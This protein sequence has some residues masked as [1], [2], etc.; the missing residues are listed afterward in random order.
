[1]QAVIK[2][3][4]QIYYFPCEFKVTIT[5]TDVTDIKN[6][7]IHASVQ[8]P[9]DTPGNAELDCLITDKAMCRRVASD[10]FKL[11]C[12]NLGLDAHKH[13]DYQEEQYFLVGNPGSQSI[14]SI[15]S[16]HGSNDCWFAVKSENRGIRVT[17][18]LGSFH[19]NIALSNTRQVRKLLIDTYITN[20][21]NITNTTK[22]GV[23]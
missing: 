16:I 15:Q 11:H 9:G 20:I 21:T 6:S 5:A 14:Q 17:S 7:K 1:M 8:L 10:F 4:Y 23:F 19:S 3:E 12:F 2:N 13:Y 18:P 22:K